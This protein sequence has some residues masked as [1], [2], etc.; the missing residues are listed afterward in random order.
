MEK[1]PK[2][3]YNGIITIKICTLDHKVQMKI[4]LLTWYNHSLKKNFFLTMSLSMWDPSSPPRDQT[5][6]PCSGSAKS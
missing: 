3:S 6:A 4:I 2:L 5:R 1:E